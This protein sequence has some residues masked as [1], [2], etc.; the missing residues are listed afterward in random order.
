MWQ[1]SLPGLFAGLFAFALLAAC[2]TAVEDDLGDEGGAGGGD[3]GGGGEMGG[4]GGAGAQGGTPIAG[5]GGAGGAVGGAGGAAGGAGGPTA[6]TGGTPAGGKGGAGAGGAAGRP[7][8]AGGTID[9][10]AEEAKV[11]PP[12]LVRAFGDTS[13]CAGSGLRF[14]D[15]FESGNQGARVGAPWTMVS[16][17]ATYDGSRTARGNRAARIST[18]IMSRVAMYYQN[19]RGVAN[20]TFWTRW[21]FYQDP[22]FDATVEHIWDWAEAAGEI[23]SNKMARFIR[24]G[25]IN[26][27]WMA[28]YVGGA[29]GLQG[30]LQKIA[31][32]ARWRCLE[33]QF[34][35][36]AAFAPTTGKNEIRLWIDNR[37][38][39]D[40]AV[41]EN[42]RDG[43]K[44]TLPEWHYIAVGYHSSQGVVRVPRIDLWIDEVAIDANRIGC[45]R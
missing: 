33:M 31:T 15:G 1:R 12:P 27:R 17:T 6:G 7:S 16:G 43:V 3:S 11:A 10:D 14:C 9:I 41:L 28:Q 8:G 24:M 4:E 38:V 30:S 21:F 18:P 32:T 29:G 22:M 35:A 44:W 37:E 5:N 45:D 39:P 42:D 34:R 25:G 26:G 19:I 40:V 23:P 20:N 36:D 2:A 13:K